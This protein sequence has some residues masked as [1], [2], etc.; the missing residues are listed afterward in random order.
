VSVLMFD[1]DHFKSINDRFGHPV[2]DEALRVFAATASANMRAADVVGRFGGEEFVAI[3]PGNL[4]DA[5]VAG[6]RVRVAFQAAAGVVADCR[7][8]GTV[9][10]GAASG[11]IDVAALIAA[12]DAALYRAK[13]G[14]RN[15]VEGIELGLAAADAPPLVPAGTEAAGGMVWHVN[16]QGR[17]A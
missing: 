13:A 17:A 15:R 14:G 2:G 7:L 6:E 11:G 4:A 8:D 5:T 1:L 12:A 3:L 9:S 16:A 10:I